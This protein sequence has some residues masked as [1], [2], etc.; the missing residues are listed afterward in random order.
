M[1]NSVN[2]LSRKYSHANMKQPR[3]LVYLFLVE[4]WERFAYYGM[5]VI[6]IFFLL[7][8]LNFDD[9]KAIQVNAA[10]MALVYATPCI[11]GY[12]ADNIFGIKRSLVLGAVFLILGYFC[13]G[14]VSS[15]LMIDYYDTEVLNRLFYISLGFIIIGNG[16]FKPNPTTLLSKVY[17]P[18]DP[19]IDSGYTIFY[20]SIN[21]GGQLSEFIIPVI[22]KHYGF[23]AAFFIC[24]IGLVIGLLWF[25]TRLKHFKH[26][27]S[28]VDFIKISFVRYLTVIFLCL[29]GVLISSEILISLNRANFVLS[30][31][32]VVVIV[33]YLYFSFTL[34]GAIG[35]RVLAS[36]Y[37]VL[38]AVV[39]FSVY[40]QIFGAM[41][42]FIHNNVDR[43]FFGYEIPAA[44]FAVI[45]PVWIVILSPFFA[46]FYILM[47]KKNKPVSIPL[48]FAIGLILASCSFLIMPLAA[49][50][51]NDGIL[52][53]WWVVLSYFFISAGELL[54]SA[55]GLAMVCKLAPPK[56]TSYFMGGFLLST[57]IGIWLSGMVGK[58]VNTPGKSPVGVYETEYFLDLYTSIF[59]KLGLISLVFAIIAIFVVP[60]INRLINTG[61]K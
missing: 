6:L 55:L 19:R 5:Q 47:E 57:S 41:N 59:F 26:I 3:E 61:H 30:V 46:K 51:A 38:M 24:S 14:L 16:F 37:L 9:S 33:S 23:S 15:S 31:A 20:M 29:L 28:P 27:G 12:V 11:G 2:S 45:N 36:F 43:V 18:N 54:V 32:S 35:K 53:A 39:F 50:T 40:A 13:L 44:T 25:I 56:M 58:F 7:Y 4:M 22:N 34:P 48:R 10:F 1:S 8:K 49:M 17:K 42:I 21:I 52:S 60:F